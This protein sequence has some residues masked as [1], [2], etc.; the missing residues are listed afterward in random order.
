[1]TLLANECFF[2]VAKPRS[3]ILM[4]PVA[5]FTKILSHFRSRCITGGVRVC[6][7]YKPSRICRHQLFRT[8]S[9]TPLNLFRYLYEKNTSVS[10]KET[11]TS[12]TIRQS[13]V[14][15]NLSFHIMKY[16]NKVCT[17]RELCAIFAQMAIIA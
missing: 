15:P 13:A 10:Y 3:P 9:R 16:S 14:L 1:M 11:I 6:R 2:K 5:P 8:F 4:R 12:S 7:K 17:S